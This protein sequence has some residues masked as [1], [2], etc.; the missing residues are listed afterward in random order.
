M[1]SI[2]PV[3]SLLI[4]SCQPNLQ[5]IER[6]G[7]RRIVIQATRAIREGEAL[8]V[9][10]EIIHIYKWLYGLFVCHAMVR[11]IEYMFRYTPFLQGR[12]TLQKW[13][14]EQRYVSCA[15][16]RCGDATEL[17]TFTR[18]VLTLKLWGFYQ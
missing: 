18:W 2:F 14:R 12:L 3:Q 17:G 6:E 11:F 9:R 16:S 10:W 5:Y 13:L 7:G 1:R 8:S 15:C 4:H